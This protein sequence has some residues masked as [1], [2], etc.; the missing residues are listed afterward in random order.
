M[1][2]IKYSIPGFYELSDLN[3][4][5]LKL[6][7]NKP[8]YFYDNFL[9]EAVYGTPQFCIWDGGRIFNQ[10]KQSSKEQIEQLI[11]TYNNI[12][13]IPI[14]YVFTNNQLKE[15]HYHDHFGN[16][17]MELGSYYNNEVVIA[18]DNF[19]LY[20]K[21]KYPNYSFISS[22]T[23]CLNTLE[24]IVQELDNS[25]YKMMC[26]DYNLNKNINFLKNIEE[27]KKDKIELL[28][29]PICLPNCLY[30][31]EHYKLNSLANLNYG[32]K[33]T[34][35][36]CNIPTDKNIFEPKAQKHHITYEDIINTYLPLGYQHFKIEGR[37]WDSKALCL[38]YCNYM[39]KPEYKNS[40][41]SILI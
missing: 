29:N 36:G 9:I 34:M 19:M 8:Q 24:E 39:V 23:K 20:L 17:C 10:A 11:Y 14:R 40:V 32:K 15:K 35:Q 28:I 5:L 27:N 6:I 3:I 37:T 21:N 41:I 2:K 12:F 38:T 16:L 26:L 30:R 7:K 1:K 13:N 25:N 18:D 4:K 22:T 33:Y 31:K